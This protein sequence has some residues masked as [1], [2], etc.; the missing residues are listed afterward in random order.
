MEKSV[1][2]H[3]EMREM[4]RY[5]RLNLINLISDLNVLSQEKILVELYLK[6]ILKHFA[7]GE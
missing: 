3:L 5:H 1:K 4:P 2:N 6:M 7:C